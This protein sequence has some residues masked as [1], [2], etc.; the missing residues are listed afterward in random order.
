MKAKCFYL[1]E[2]SCFRQVLQRVLI[3]EC[4][5]DD[6]QVVYVLTGPYLQ[7]WVLT[8]D[9]E[10]VSRIYTGFTLTLSV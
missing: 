8:A 4:A 7:K 3:G 5:D 6:T 9:T 2:Q 1:T 10:K